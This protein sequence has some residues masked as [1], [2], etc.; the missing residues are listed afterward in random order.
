MPT[1][2]NS[3]A[4]TSAAITTPPIAYLL[5]RYP[6]V[7]HTFFLHEVLGLRALGCISKLHR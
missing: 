4:T 7:S 3:P 6:A 5:S 1:M 2:S